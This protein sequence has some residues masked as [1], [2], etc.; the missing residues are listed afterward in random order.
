MG[1]A[2][3]DELGH[4][5]PAEQ[6]GEPQLVAAGEEYAGRRL[7]PPQSSGLLAVAASIKIHHS[8]LRSAQVPEEFLVARAGLVHAAG[9]GDHDDIGSRAAREADGAIPGW[10]MVFLIF[11]P[12]DGHYPAAGL[13]MGNFAGHEA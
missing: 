8:H 2:N 1:V 11:A 5:R 10:A 7:E 12:A 9:G 4:R 6:G 3:A 13:A